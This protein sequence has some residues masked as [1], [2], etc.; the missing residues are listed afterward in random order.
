MADYRSRRQT[1]C[2]NMGACAENNKNLEYGKN[3]EP[4]TYTVTVSIP[5]T[6]SNKL[7]N[8]VLIMT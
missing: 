4:I 8:A 7:P 6:S 1:T 3:M 2:L 5:A